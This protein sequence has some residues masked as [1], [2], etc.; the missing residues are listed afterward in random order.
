MLL[1]FLIDCFWL[2]LHA[3]AQVEAAEKAIALI[4]PARVTTIVAHLVCQ[5]LLNKG[6]EWVGELNESGILKDQ[7]TEHFL[8]EIQNDLDSI[9][10]CHGEW[11]LLPCAN[12]ETEATSSRVTEANNREVDEMAALQAQKDE[13][14]RLLKQAKDKI[15]T[16]EEKDVIGVS[17]VKEDEEAESDGVE[18]MV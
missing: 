15:N 1:L 10:H 7:E 9:A 11:V 6:A 2:W 5:I 3:Q 12:E 17:K 8:E 4:D 13:L 14:E 16:L 18:D